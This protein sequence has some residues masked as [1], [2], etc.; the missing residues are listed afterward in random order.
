MSINGFSKFN[1]LNR[2]NIDTEL[3]SRIAHVLCKADEPGEFNY[4]VM[5]RAVVDFL[6]DN[7]AICGEACD[8]GAGRGREVAARENLDDCGDY[9]RFPRPEQ[10]QH[11]PEREGAI[12]ASGAEFTRAERLAALLTGTAAGEEGKLRG[13]GVMAARD[14]AE[15]LASFWYQGFGKPGG[16]K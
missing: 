3:E 5:A 13:G 11:L 6:A 10:N 8:A 12:I 15:A 9:Y 16:D 7:A 14:V 1:D 2:E 4:G